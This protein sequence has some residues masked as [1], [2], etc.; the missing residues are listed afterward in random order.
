[1]AAMTFEQWAARHPAAAAELRTTLVPA[2][3]TPMPGASEAAVQQQVRYRAALAGDLLLRNNVGVL[4]DRRGVPVRFGLANDSRAMNE[5]VKSAD[6][7][8]IRRLLITP[9]HV[10]QT[11][12]IFYSRECKEGS[13]RWSGSAREWAQ[14]EWA[15]IVW[16]HGGDACIVNSA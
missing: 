6:L 3:S 4:K 2:P 5:H 12:G 9:A 11:L 13:W 14:L 16:A 1:M 8:G 7:I 10:G 15:T